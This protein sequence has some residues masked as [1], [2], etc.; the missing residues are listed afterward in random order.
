MHK[1]WPENRSTRNSSFV[2]RFCA[3]SNFHTI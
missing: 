2:Y 1:K 3:P